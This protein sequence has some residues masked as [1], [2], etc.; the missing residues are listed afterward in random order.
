MSTTINFGID[1]GTT[2]SLIAKFANGGVEIFKNPMGLKE[3]L[4]SVV[5]FRKDRVLVGDKA[6]ELVEKDPENVFS[7]FK[8]KMGT[9][10]SFFVQNTVSFKSPMEL[11]ALVLK[12]LKN[13]VYTGEKVQAAVITIPA[14]FDTI[15]SNA[16][17]K[18]GYEA[19][20]EEVV[21][22]QE[23][24]AAS[25]A[26]ANKR[27]QGESMQGQWLVYDLG[28][29][30]FDVALVKFDDGEMKVLDHEGDNYL[31]GM[32]FDNAIIEK[33][34]IPSL[35]A[36]YALT[37]VPTEL[38]SAKG[39]FNTLYYVL[40]KKAEEVK[41]QLS[42]NVAAEIEFEIRDDNGEY[43]EVCITVTR[44]QFDE[45]I[46]GSIGYS[47]EIVKKIIERNKLSKG[48]VEEVILIGGST[49]I[50]LVK[51]LLADQ[52]GIPVNASVDPTTAVAVGAAYYAGTK[53]ATVKA[54]VPAST[55][56]IVTNNTA[57]VSF[58]TAYQKSTQDREEYFTAAVSGEI[59][60]L[61][62]RI[63]RTDGGFD[64]ALKPLKERISEML[65][66]APNASNQ[67]HLQVYDKKNNPVEVNASPIEI[68]QGKFTVQ[69]QP[70][71]NDICIEV[72]DTENNTTRLEVVF[73]KNSI[74]PLRKTI[75]KELVKTIT[76]R[77]GDSL[78]INILE[79][80]RFSIPS[81]C[82]PI[83]V[84]EIKGSDLEVDAI[85][86]SDIE[87]TLNMSESRDLT[88]TAVL[89]IN[90][91]EFSNVFNTS[92]RSVN[93]TKM[94]EEVK[95]MLHQANKDVIDFQE[96]E[97]YEL[98]SKVQHINEEL[99]LLL[100]RLRKLSVDDVTDEKYQLE[101]RKRKLAQQLDA[102]GK[103]QKIVEITEEYFE[104]KSF[105]EEL[106]GEAGD[107][108]RLQ[109]LQTITAKE[110]EYLT[111]QSYYSIE[112]KKQEIRKLAWEVQRNQDHVWIAL[113][114]YYSARPLQDYK[115]QKQAKQYIEIGEKAME[116]KNYEELKVATNTLYNLLPDEKRDR[117][118]IKGTGI[119]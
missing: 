108:A 53:T 5:A 26:F 11:S 114:Y 91:Q 82:V 47:I 18:A 35:E 14:S 103:D 34:V 12:E 54:S 107:T 22:L 72:D 40:L 49:Y 10:E 110:K 39:K 60:G 51:K 97:Q 46:M 30:T 109:K 111:S 100:R 79:G 70:L 29:G 19:G 98:A 8:R 101:E 84:I 74:L 3:T 113:F 1:L 119:G 87:I 55:S 106:L 33:I 93:L 23:P 73:E 83:G 57:K 117:E 81:S 42:H 102:L 77:S 104:E 31:G 65:V 56:G 4:P 13:F 95:L 71:P 20:F 89:M 118:R 99:L 7:G 80:N 52:L 94:S 75:M 17:K 24:I 2:N 27:E 50:P 62:Y 28:G 36:N 78:I 105:C 25:L 67:F 61:F 16:T 58:K 92:E 64:S 21:L 116:R 69:G 115:D 96:K 44:Q 90:D 41:I 59:E 86:G 38:K 85:K 66:L 6:R 45:C 37:N 68:V 76:R 112:A 63:V 15:Q 9:S 88:I 43:Q 32:D 48:D